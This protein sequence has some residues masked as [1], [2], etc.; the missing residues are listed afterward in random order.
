[1][2]LTAYRCD[3]HGQGVPARERAPHT[4]RK[5]RWLACL[6]LLLC[7]AP[8]PLLAQPAGAIGDGFSFRRPIISLTVRGGYDRP[9][10][11]SDIFDFTT[12]NLTVSKGDFAAASMQ[13]DLGIRVSDRIEIVASG[14]SA[15]R[16]A[17]SEFRN[18]IDNNDQPIEQSTRLRRVPISLGV[19]YALTAPAEQIGKFAWIPSRV[20]LWAGAGAGGMDYDFSQVGDFVDFETLN[21]FRDELTSS[22]VAPMVYGSLAGE[23]KLSTR[24]SLTADVRYTYARARLSDDF[25][26]FNKIDLSGT[27]AT[28]GFTFRL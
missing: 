14:G 25:L 9:M 13:V 20:T 12:K 16:E 26:G 17:S 10:A 28:M 6:C 5:L 21:V 18:F 7:I 24:M 22:G 3:N 1:M 27:A 2:T 4:P 8:V 23:L 11:G 15:R 19:R